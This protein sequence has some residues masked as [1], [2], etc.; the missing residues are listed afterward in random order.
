[1][2]P[3]L[4]GDRLFITDAGIETVLIY[5][6]GIELPCFAS[7]TVLRDE[8][9][10]EVVRDYFDRF[11]DIAR[12]QQFGVL[13]DTLTW[14]ASK[15]WGDQLGYSSEDLAAV[16]HRAAIL[17]QEI[18]RDHASD[19]TPILISGCV[20]PRGDAYSPDELMSADEAM[21]Y[22]LAQIVTLADAGVDMIT[23][24]TLTYVDEAIGI[25]RAAQAA[26]IPVVIS[27]TVE[28][29]GRL[30]S[31]QALRWAIE[32]TDAATGSGAAYFM[33]NCAHPSHF[34]DVLDD[35]GA[36]RERIR[37]VRPNASKKS[38]AELDASDELDAGD[39][40]E[41][42]ADCASL[43]ALLPNLTVV[44]GCC[45]TDH[46]HMAAASAAMAGVAR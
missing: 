33:V 45:G 10:T 2:L 32:D 12:R 6:E 17:A 13:L 26:D 4:T 18:R 39:P 25:V 9:Q 27:F 38:H 24:L 23:A 15:D 30:P 21:R 31:G 7:F 8:Q 29:N 16:N 5:H 46:R 19:N 20:G 36:W 35:G 28:T 44:G 34:A 11:L 41:W 43:R 42:G 1:M 22:H 40:D 3:Q 37:G 14:R